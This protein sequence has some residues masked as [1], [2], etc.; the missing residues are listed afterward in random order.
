ML[1]QTDNMNQMIINDS[2]IFYI[3][4]RSINWSVNDLGHF[5]QK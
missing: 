2:K 3:N 1:I 4:F 5:F